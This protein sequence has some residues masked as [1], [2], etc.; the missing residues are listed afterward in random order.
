ME[1]TELK[2]LVETKFAFLRNMGLKALDL[3]PNR[4]KLML[5]KKGNENHLGTVWAGALFT[6]AEVPGGI[7][8]FTSFDGSKFYPVVKEMNI[9]FVKPATTDVTIEIS[10]DEAEAARV[11]KEAEEKGKADFILDG[12]LMDAN[13]NVVAVTRGFYQLRKY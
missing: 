13:D 10:M 2:E 5:P 7:L 3:A 4:V 9:K 6:L 12:E 1:M 11:E 8:V